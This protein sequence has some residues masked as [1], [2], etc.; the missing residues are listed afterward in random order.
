MLILGGLTPRSQ[1]QY[2]LLQPLAAVPRSRIT[3][4]PRRTSFLTARLRARDYSRADK[5]A[6]L[7]QVMVSG[8]LRRLIAI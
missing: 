3:S 2:P 4:T 1:P 6:A 5:T 7:V 8:Y